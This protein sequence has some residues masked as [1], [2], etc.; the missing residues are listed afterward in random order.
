MDAKQTG[1]F[2]AKKRKE[3]KLTQT[4]L[5][6]LLQVTDKAISRWETGEGYPEISF[7]PKLSTILGCTIDDILQGGQKE[8]VKTDVRRIAP[9]FM[10]FSSLSIALFLF[11]YLINIILIYATQ[12]KYWSLLSIVVFG[13]S[14]FVLYY[15]QRYQYLLNCNY[16]DE[17]KQRIQKATRILYFTSILTIFA[18][19][20]QY[21]VEIIGNIMRV[22]VYS[23]EQILR[24]GAYVISAVIYVLIALIPILIIV[25]IQQ[26]NKTGKSLWSKI[27][28]VRLMIILSTMIMLFLVFEMVIDQ[29]HFSI[30]FFDR[31]LYIIP[32]VFIIPSLYPLIFNDKKTLIPLVLNILLVPGLYVAANAHY[33][34]F[35]DYQWIIDDGYNSFITLKYV[36]PGSLIVLVASIYLII[37]EKREN[38]DRSYSFYGYRNLIFLSSFLILFFTG[39]SFRNI[40]HSIEVLSATYIACWYI[41]DLYLKLTTRTTK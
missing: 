6:E 25:S 32:I 27:T 29:Y 4:E 31:L 30:E 35:R 26:Q 20:P 5:A 22:P 40:Y 11:G 19:L 3:K 13:F 41:S 9:K 8:V 17:D 34:A 12:E 18:L 24:F 36:G 23:D 33:D 38:Q 7:L 1:I 16:D 37:K 14:A 15:F 39:I 2:I 21:T 10:F 28:K